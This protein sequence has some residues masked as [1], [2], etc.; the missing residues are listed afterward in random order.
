M[1][2]TVFKGLHAIFPER[3]V[4][5]T[6]GVT[7]RRWLYNCNPPLRNLLHE[8]IGDHWVADL[9]KIDVLA[10]F[11]D[12]GEFRARFA[13]AKRENKVR[14]ANEIK[15]RSG[16]AVDPDALFDVQIKRIHEYKRQLLNAL[17]TVARYQAIRANPDRDWQPV[18]KIFGGKA[19]PGYATAKLI[20]KMINDIARTVNADTIVGDRLYVRNA[21]EIACFELKLA[22]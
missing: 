19:A 7:P 4:N 13:N 15:K 20:I 12:D 8:T 9:G 22:E 2:E 6:N 17:Q 11:A 21:E 3:I 5:V 16:L 10:G 18:V 1:K 14:L